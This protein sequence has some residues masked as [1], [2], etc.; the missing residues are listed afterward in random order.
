ML[1]PKGLQA[2]V[3]ALRS[4]PDVQW[5]LELE[6][7]PS[8]DL[9]NGKKFEPTPQL[10]LRDP[11]LVRLVQLLQTEVETGSPTGNL[12][13][14]TIGNSLIL[15]LAQHYSTAMPRQDQTRGGLPG[16]RLKRVLEYIEANLSR[17]MHLNE[18]GETA[19]LSAFHF[20][21]LFKQSTGASPHQYILQRRLE[22]AKELLRKPTMSLSEIGLESGFADQ[23]HFTNVFRRFA[24][25]TP[26]KFRSLL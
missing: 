1:A 6:P 16:L 21:K 12:F 8:Q 19:G 20:A 22:R 25:V 11:Q 15:Y 2:S 5:I 7:S 17:E 13:G 18:L 24:G 23:S 14:E 26:S 4:Q 3:R 9:L 10:N